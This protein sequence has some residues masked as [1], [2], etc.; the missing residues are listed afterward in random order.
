MGLTTSGLTEDF[1]QAW[2]WAT[3]EVNSPT[4]EYKDKKPSEY[5]KEIT[6]N[7]TWRSLQSSD[8]KTV[9]GGDD[10]F[11]EMVMTM[12]GSII[13][14]NPD[15]ADKDAD[16]KL[17]KLNGH[18]ITLAEL[19]EGGE[20]KIYD[21]DSNGA[22]ECL[23]PPLAPS[24]MISDVGLKSRISDSLVEVFNSFKTEAEWS[25]TAKDALSFKTLVGAACLDKIYTAAN[26]NAQDN[27]AL[28]IADLCAGRMA[29]EAS[30]YQV[31]SYI[32]TAQSALANAGSSDSQQVAKEQANKMLEESAEKYLQ[33]FEALNSTYPTSSIY[34]TL[35]TI[36]FRTT[37]NDTLIGGE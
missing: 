8:A 11:L 20:F 1:N 12:V 24:K 14:K 35:N 16:P 5:A 23:N 28:Q 4:E 9:F 26:S 21:C 10:Q 6:G 34:L 30:Y 18:G 29:L 31:T 33:E 17:I 3:E 27:I 25:Q 37:K 7:L 22:D 15:S 2:S 19:I 13:I 32:R 36:Q